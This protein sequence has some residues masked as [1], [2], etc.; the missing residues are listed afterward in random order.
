[1][2]TDCI[3]DDLTTQAGLRMRARRA[4]V[5]A[6]AEL[7]RSPVS[8]DA[9]FALG[10][11]HCDRGDYAEGRRLLSQGVYFRTESFRGYENL[12][13]LYIK[14]GR[15]DDACEAYAEWARV[16]PSRPR[17]LGASSGNIQTMAGYYAIRADEYDLTSGYMRPGNRAVEGLKAR[18][19]AAFKDENVLEVA[20][21]TGYWTAVV[22]A[23]ARSIVATDY[24]S[25]LVEKVQ[26]KLAA[27]PNVRCQ[28]A[29]AYSLHGVTGHFTGAFAQFWWSH[30][31]K[32]SVRSFLTTLHSRLQPN[33]RVM[34]T[35]SLPYEWDGGRWIDEAGD[36]QEERILRSGERHAVIKNFPTRSDIE[37]ALAG[38]ARDVEF[39]QDNDGGVWHLSYRVDHL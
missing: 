9:L 15:P 1:M 31:P 4:E 33:A 38:I 5:A 25:V 28:V 16:F 22:A 3:A 34:F 14:L 39:I 6:R 21:G 27:F 26:E 20:C 8:A 35:D 12:A 32:A 13:N 19:Q 37:A 10:A 7:R 2:A 18:Y 11:A 36:V 23:T 24:N 29:N 30:I 17:G